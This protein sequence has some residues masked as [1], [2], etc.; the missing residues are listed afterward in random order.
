MPSCRIGCFL[1][2]HFGKLWM[3]YFS[4]FNHKFVFASRA[5]ERDNKRKTKV[6]LVKDRFLPNN[7]QEICKKRFCGGVF[8]SEELFEF[9]KPVIKSVAYE[10]HCFV[11]CV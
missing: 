2:A 4:H 8:F 5:H 10:A 7:A 1:S 9:L 11:L 3:E 6:F